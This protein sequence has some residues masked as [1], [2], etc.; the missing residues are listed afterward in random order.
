MFL[1]IPIE[2]N[3]SA[4]KLSDAM[5]FLFIHWT[6]DVHTH[7]QMRLVYEYVGEYWIVDLCEYWVFIDRNN[8]IIL[9]LK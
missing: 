4:E 8:T 1:R 9:A 3:L 7:I 5:N 2:I 6:T